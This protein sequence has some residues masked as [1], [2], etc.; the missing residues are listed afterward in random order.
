MQGGITVCWRQL[1]WLQEGFLCIWI[2]SGYRQGREVDGN[3]Q[4]RLHTRRV[5]NRSVLPTFPGP[6]RP[7]FHAPGRYRSWN[8]KKDPGSRSDRFIRSQMSVGVG[9]EQDRPEARSE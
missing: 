4:T 7:G 9:S 5:G 8:N 1:L 2:S 6:T 3:K